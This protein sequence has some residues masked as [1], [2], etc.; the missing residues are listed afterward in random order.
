MK[1]LIVFT[2][3]MMG[4]ATAFAQDT[5]SGAPRPQHPAPPHAPGSAGMEQPKLPPAS[6]RVK[7]HTEWLKEKLNLSAEQEKA[8]G[9]INTEEEAKRDELMKKGNM[10]PEQQQQIGKASSEKIK[11]L[12]NAE[13]KKKFDALMMPPK[14]PVNGQHPQGGPGA[15]PPP[16]PAPN[17]QH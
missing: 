15:P 12:L 1:K 13:Q 2:L 5:T 11:K 8:V 9:K 16:P 6:E 4:A 14:P 7:K 3:L 10:T 17:D